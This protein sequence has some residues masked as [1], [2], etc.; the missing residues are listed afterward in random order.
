MSV[1]HVVA[2]LHSGASA[3]AKPQRSGTVDATGL[4]H[5]CAIIRSSLSV[6]RV[7]GLVSNTLL[8]S[9]ASVAASVASPSR[10]LVLIRIAVASSRQSCR[11]RT[12]SDILVPRAIR[13]KR[14]ERFRC[15]GPGFA[16]GGVTTRRFGLFDRRRSRERFA[17]K[18]FIRTTVQHANGAVAPGGLVRSCHGGARLICNVSLAKRTRRLSGTHLDS[19]GRPVIKNLFILNAVL[20]FPFGVLALAAP[21]TLFAQFG[22]QLDAAGELIARG[23]GA[24]LVAYGVVLCL[25]GQS[26]DRR[27][28]RAFLLSMVLFNSIEAVIQS[29]AGVQGIAAK[30]I[31]G[32]VAIHSAVA[33]LSVIALSKQQ[34]M[35][36]TR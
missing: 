34:S 13:G 9:P 2:L 28:I 27:T 12:H 3:G 36:R 32:N 11:A 22:L 8:R 26:A 31:F 1:A 18:R 14:P 4:F 21:A 33:V 19:E 5:A 10:R 16:T 35:L 20:T 29:S 23:Y 7:V 15:R 24:T 17:K 25:V 6:P 30:M